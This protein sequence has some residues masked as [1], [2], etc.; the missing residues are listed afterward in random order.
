[1]V[2]LSKAK[3]PEEEATAMKGARAA[4]ARYAKLARATSVVPMMARARYLRVVAARG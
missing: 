2:A 1:L 4:G 3:S